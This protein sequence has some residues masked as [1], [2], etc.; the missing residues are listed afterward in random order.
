MTSE[1]V[2]YI[3][4]VKVMQLSTIFQLYRG[5]QLYWWGNR[6]N[7]RKFPICCKSLTLYNRH[8]KLLLVIHS[9]LLRNAEAWDRVVKSRSHLTTNLRSCTRYHLSGL[10]TPNHGRVF[11]LWVRYDCPGFHSPS[12]SGGHDRA[13]TLLK[14]TLNTNNPSQ[15]S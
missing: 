15:A 9:I 7:R 10:Q 14:V 8:S 6:S 4:K 3:Y 1:N 2:Y 13:E 12:K 5:G 11:P